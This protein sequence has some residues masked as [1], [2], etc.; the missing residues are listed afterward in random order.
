[1]EFAFEME[2]LYIGYFICSKD[3]NFYVHKLIDQKENSQHKHVEP[4]ELATS[5]IFPFLST[6]QSNMVASIF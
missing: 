5:V 1:M 6:G 2:L 3:L 4:T